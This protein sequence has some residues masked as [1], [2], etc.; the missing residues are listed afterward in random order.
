MAFNVQ[1]TETRAAIEH[2]NT[3]LWYGRLIDFPGT[4]ARAQGKEQLLHNLQEELDYH[5]NWLRRHK[6]PVPKQ[7]GYTI[8][9]EEEVQGIS[10]LGESGGEAAFFELDKQIVDKK[11]LECL[12]RYMAHNREDLVNTVINLDKKAMDRIPDGKGRSI[13]DILAHICNA[14]EFYL[15]RL[16]EKAD[17][18]YEQNLEMEVSEADH[19]PIFERLEAVRTAC[20]KTLR[21]LAPI[22]GEGIFTRIEY[23]AYP[24]ERWSFYKVLRRFLEHEREHIYNIREYLGL[25]PREFDLP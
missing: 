17:E 12:L 16:G 21:E 10:E 13:R 20:V 22:K 7:P 2:G 9:V 23:T 3:G 24:S 1:K 14:E 4:H 25:A 5:L 6:Q 18:L 19:L 11:K 8:R 15:S